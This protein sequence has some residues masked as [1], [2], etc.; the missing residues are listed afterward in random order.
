[1]KKTL[2]YFEG[3][4]YYGFLTNNETITNDESA[5]QKRYYRNDLGLVFGGGI[6]KPIHEVNLIL[7]LRYEM[8][9]RKVDKLDNELRNKTLSLSI[10]YQ[11]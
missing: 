9:L 7:G 11:F 5:D 2:L 8:G 6:I 1:M 4:P 3:G 10:G